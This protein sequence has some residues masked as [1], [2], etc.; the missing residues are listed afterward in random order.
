MTAVV[1]KCF[2]ETFWWLVTGHNADSDRKCFLTHT[3]KLEL[4]GNRIEKGRKVQQL[5][6]Y[7]HQWQRISCFAWGLLAL[8]LY[9]EA[10]L[11]YGPIPSLHVLV[12]PALFHKITSCFINHIYTTKIQEKIGELLAE[13]SEDELH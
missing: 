9:H 11:D 10:R 6:D 1:C 5:T 3:K 8:N 2:S 13:I 7:K 4:T 12:L